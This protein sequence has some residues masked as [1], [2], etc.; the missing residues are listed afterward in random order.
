VRGVIER[1]QDTIDA[2]A[3]RL[4]YRDNLGGP[5]VG[6]EIPLTDC[7]TTLYLLAAR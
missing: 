2:G 6:A 3:R 7:Q 5:R 4:Q 1:S